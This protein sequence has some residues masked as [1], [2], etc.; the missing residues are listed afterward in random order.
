MLFIN[1]NLPFKSLGYDLFLNLLCSPRCCIYLILNTELLETLIH[2]SGF[3]E[4]NRKQKTEQKA[5]KKAFLSW[6]LSVDFHPLYQMPSHYIDSHIT[7]HSGLHPIFHCTDYLYTHYKKQSQT[8][9]QRWVIR[10]Y[11]S[12]SDSYI[13]EPSV[14]PDS[15]LVLFIVWFLESCIVVCLSHPVCQLPTLKL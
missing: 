10:V 2:F 1:S 4:Q 9:F 11:R 5:K 15:S 8:T 3:A 13:T 14:F 7:C 12:P 6:I